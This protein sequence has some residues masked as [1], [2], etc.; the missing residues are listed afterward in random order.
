MTVS[1][2]TRCAIEKALIQTLGPSAIDHVVIREEFDHADEEALFL[3]VVM[4][5]SD[6]PLTA[7]KSIDAR[8]AVSD[9]LLE[10][11]DPRFPYMRFTHPDDVSVEDD[12]SEQRS[13]RS[14]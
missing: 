12:S 2:S 14:H 8:V 6:Q 4:K 13:T 7:D 9:A 5:R 11:S 1:A 10:L 3:E